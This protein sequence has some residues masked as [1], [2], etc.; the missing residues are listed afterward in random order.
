MKSVGSMRKGCTT[1]ASYNRK[2]YTMEFE[3]IKESR[4]RKV[5][6]FVSRSGRTIR[7]VH[8]IMS[9]VNPTKVT[10]DTRQQSTQGVHKCDCCIHNH[11]CQHNIRIRGRKIKISDY[12]D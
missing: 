10:D 12:T 7:P 2:A 8:E 1:I 3:R 9:L 6:G 11:V 5:K 4:I